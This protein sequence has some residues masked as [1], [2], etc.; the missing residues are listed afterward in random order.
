MATPHRAAALTA[1][2]PFLAAAMS[3]AIPGTDIAPNVT[4]PMMAFG[5]ANASFA[6]ACTVP[7]AVEQWLRLGGRHLD[8]SLLYG[9][10][11]EVAKG[12][13]NSGVPRSELF[14]TTKVEGPV[15]FSEAISQV[16]NTDL[17]QVGVEYFDLVLIHCPCHDKADFPDKC[18]AK[19][20]EDRID[21]WRGLEQLRKDGKARA[22]GVSNFNGE[23]VR[24]LTDAGYHPAVN[25]VEWHLGY[26]NDTFLEEM[27]SLGVKV[28]A[29]SPLS[30]PT[31]RHDIPGISLSD[32][33][34]RAV[35][36]RY[37]ASTA[38]VALQWSI[39]KGVTPVTATCNR[40]H[41]V[42]DLETMSFS[43]SDADMLYLD[44]L[45]E[46]PFSSVFV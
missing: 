16:T 43:L 7:E 40:S 31:K 35:A 34:L 10:Q 27:K 28:E 42:G 1:C 5:T 37:N 24:Q 41:A 23:Q 45:K 9:T 44:G 6:G 36:D 39:K 3:S 30:G 8:M 14:L 11:P 4:M 2:A 19:F 29:W 25:Q 46:Q 33:R 38:Q 26:H 20:K 13:V 15:G 18:G 21:T 22:I 17:Q 12:I 32:P